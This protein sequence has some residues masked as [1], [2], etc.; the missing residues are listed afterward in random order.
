MLPTQRFSSR[1]E[2]YR[3]Y[4]PG[5]PGGIIRDLLTMGALSPRAAVADVGS[6]TGL[7]ARLFLENGNTVFGVEPNDAMRAAGE[8]ELRGFPRFSSIP[9]TA[10]ATSLPDGAVDLVIAGQAF[11]WFDRPR[12][13]I[14]FQRVL[15]KEPGNRWCALIWNE[16]LTD[17]SPFLRAYE[18]ML[19]RFSTDYTKTDH[20][21]MTQE[22]ITAFFEPRETVTRTYPNEQVFDFAQ[23]K[24]RLLSSSYAPPAGHPN[25]EPM[26]VELAAIFDAARENGR[27]RFEYRAEMT[28]GRL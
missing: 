26:L 13:R 11:H 5:Y 14:E 23:L 12:T 16:R 9:G 24:G 17:A 10:E 20:R 1:V 19:K 4:R 22:V 6:G 2:D 15:R 18:E 8:E 21:Q 7:L 25:H 28:V 3:K 27:V